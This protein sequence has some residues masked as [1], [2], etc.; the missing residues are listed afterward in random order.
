[1][2][3]QHQ[4]NTES[5]YTNNQISEALHKTPSKPVGN[6]EGAKVRSVGVCVE[7]VGFNVGLAVGLAVVGVIAGVGLL[8]ASVG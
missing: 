4:K 1:M 6:C 8:L 2:K 5:N 3:A 7:A